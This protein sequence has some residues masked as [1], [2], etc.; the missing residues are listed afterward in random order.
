MTVSQPKTIIANERVIVML[1]KAKTLTGY[2][3]RCLDGEIGDVKEFVFDENEWTIRYLTVETGTWLIDREVLI[4]TAAIT[5]LDKEEKYIAVNLT[6]QQIEDSPLLYKANPISRQFET[7][8]HN[9]YGYTP[10]W[11][12]WN[13]PPV[14]QPTSAPIWAPNPNLMVDSSA[15]K[16]ATQG[17]RDLDPGLRSTG[18]VRGRKL[19]ALDGEI[20]HIADFILD[21]EDWVIRYLDIDTI[22]WWP[23]KHVLI[24][25]GWIDSIGWE[26]FL[27]HVGLTREQIKSSP[28]YNKDSDLERDYE[29]C[30]FDHYERRGY[31]DDSTTG[32]TNNDPEK[33]E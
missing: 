16:A 29:Q 28:E 20:G 32:D 10:Y 6:R 25:P 21:H 30:L 1:T 5:A 17:D 24:C 8:Y 12:I 26:D 4:S 18:N 33:K 22:S 23:S 9:Y 13:T 19:Q 7:S 2:K 27:V 15:Y 14:T 3:L 11:N 31:W